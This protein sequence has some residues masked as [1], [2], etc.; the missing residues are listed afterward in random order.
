MATTIATMSLSSNDLVTNVLGLSTTATLTQAGNST[1]LVLTSG[2]ARTNFTDDPIHQKLIYRGDDAT[3][4]G[5]NKIY[6]KIA[7]NIRKSYKIGDSSK[8]DKHMKKM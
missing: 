4:D 6:M 8:D 7:Q 5:A 3:S 1:G 2:L